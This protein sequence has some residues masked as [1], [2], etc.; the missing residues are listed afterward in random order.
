[1]KHR[2]TVTNYFNRRIILLMVL[3]FAC[4]WVL[5]AQQIT[6]KVTSDEGEPLPG[7][8]ILIQGT[9]SGGAV[10]DIDGKYSIKVPDS[11]ASLV[12]SFTGFTKQAVAVNGRSVVD[13]VLAS[14]SKALDEVVVIGYGAVR[15]KDL[16]GSVTNVG[17]KIIQERQPISLTEALQGQAAGV[18][19]TT[20][21]DPTSSGDIQIRGNSSLNTGNGPL[22]VID[23]VISDNAKAINPLDIESVDILKD[24]SSAA[25]YG[26]RGANGVILI[27]TKS[28]K[29]GKPTF[30]VNY[31]SLWGKLSH[32]LRTTTADELRYYRKMR[33][34]GNNGANTDSVNYFLNQDNDYQDVLFRVSRKQTISMSVSGGSAAASNKG[35]TLSGNGLNYYCGLDYTDYQALVY[36]SWIKRAQSR[37]NVTYRQSKL[38]V[39]NNLSWA[40]ETGNIINV[41]NT[42][43]QIWEKNP[44]TSVYRPDGGLASTIES[45][46]NPLAQALLATN[47]EEIFTAQNNTQL[48]YQVFKD[49]RFTTSFNVKLNT[50]RDWVMSPKAISTATPQ[51]NSGNNSYDNTFFWLYQA[52]LNY[53]K[54]I[55]KHNITGMVGF[56]ADRTAENTSIISYLNILDENLFTSNMGT[57]DITSS[58]KTGTAATAFSS[59]S[60]FGRLG[61][62]YEG[63][64]LLQGT[65]RRDGSSRFGS[66]NKWGNFLSGS[67]AWRFSDESFMNWSK[68]FL[69]DGKLRYSIG[70]TGNDAIGNYSSYTLFDVGSEKYLGTNVVA[71]SV[72]MGNSRIKWETTTSSDYG[73]D[74]SFFKGRLTLTADYY[75]KTTDNLLYNSALPVESGKTKV[76]VNLGSIQNKGL[77]FTVTGVPIATRDFSWN[78]SGNISFQQS[79]VKELANNTPFLSGDKWYLQEGGKIGDFYVWKNLGVYQWD[80]SNAYVGDVTSK[81]F[82]KKLT[83]VLDPATGTPNGTYTLNGDVYSGTIQK[84]QRS[85][86]TLQGGDTEWVD[87]NNDG[88]IDDKDK[89]ICGNAL[90][91]YFFGINSV[92]RYKNFSFSFFIN[93]E[94]G[95]DVYNR[96]A[97]NQNA[98]SSTYSPPIYD[99]IL[100]SWQKQG[101]ISKYPLFSRKDTRGSISSG[102]NSLYIEDGSFI[103]LSSARLT[104]SFDPKIINRAG[105]RSASV[106]VYGNNLITWTNYSWYDPEFTLKGLQP[107]E[108]NGKYPRTREV[109]LGV[110]LNF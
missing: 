1:M 5:Q 47:K 63:K 82:G 42:A 20:D 58:S 77:E 28:G 104:Y 106:F 91:K 75:V 81:D 72:T 95:N 97:N 93:S 11:K 48:A 73:L 26:A 9:T 4:G 19:V 53:N 24:A 3:F 79:K 50:E 101:D 32:K 18:F 96:V 60:F 62:S 110:T 49:L 56:S 71:E 41:G 45:K 105:V 33:G 94:F 86:I 22:Y 52:Y 38:E 54:S 8:N 99:A 84:K 55:G 17:E 83:V 27:T 23:G 35:I 92:I 43:K 89:L 37:V 39:S 12:F 90:P 61:Y 40:Y 74:L 2:K 13:V 80:A 88:V 69:Q 108:D 87:V 65:Y 78:V 98:N 7:V 44:W 68:S 67:A 64:Y 25:I 31:T 109:G 29:S 51:T 10:T 66:Q 103:R 57:V 107:G 46:R 15:K 16:T 59:A 70:Q 102:T 6:G 76:Y 100:T 21:G 34:D 36:N 14:E 30:N 85:G